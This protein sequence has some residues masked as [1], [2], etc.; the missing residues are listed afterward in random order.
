M[1]RRPHTNSLL[2]GRAAFNLWL[3][4]A[5]LQSPEGASAQEAIRN[6]LAAQTAA[7]THPINL[8]SLP[9][10]FKS[11]DFRLLLAPSLE[12]DWN[13]NINLSKTNTLQDFILMPM[14]QI[15]ASYPITQVN[16]LRL[17]VGFG[18]DE[19]LEHNAYNNWRVNSGSQ[20]SFDTYIKDVLINLHDRFSYV[21][22]AGSQAVVAGAGDYGSANNVAGVSLAWNPKDINLSLG[23]D[24]KNI[25]SP[26]GQF[27]SQDSS[28]ELIDGRVGWRFEPTATAGVEA[29]Y[30]ST[31]YDEAVLNNFTSYTIG[32]YGEWK[33]GSYFKVE[34]RAGYVIY[35]FQQT[36]ASA[37]TIEPTGTGI[38]VV[39]LTGK[40]IQ[41][42]DL[43]SWYAD[44]TLSHDITRAL[45]YSLSA[46]H[47]IQ[48]GIQSDAVEDSYLRLS[49]TWKII[50]NLSLH[51]SFSYQ[52]GQQGV[53]NI[54]GNLSEIFD[55]Y[56][57][58]VELSHQLTT[59]LRLGLNYRITLRSSTDASLEYTQ[60]LVGLQ[61]TY[62]FQ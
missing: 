57:G 28:S 7:E 41:T 22:D 26:M 52:H 4:A 14:M 23:Y 27:Q 31:A 58:G 60:N 29:T 20:L 49:S 12:L 13:D 6:V 45:S 43:N 1:N 36:S 39:A 18:Y 21:Q 33:P 10:T 50:K 51:S 17:D 53:G 32:A 38:P 9:Y 47:E 40:P 55:W 48:A 24:H 56:T 35:D 54:T 19:Y 34:P 2:A 15:D 11:G 61:M 42:S 25:M 3:M 5:V 37:E 46:G 8:E 59:R 30:S 44:L 16:L 62:A